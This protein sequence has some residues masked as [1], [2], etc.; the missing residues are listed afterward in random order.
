[1]QTLLGEGVEEFTQDIDGFATDACRP[2]GPKEQVLSICRRAKAI[3]EQLQNLLP[4]F[5]NRAF[6]GHPQFW[7][8]GLGKI[9]RK[10]VGHVLDH[11]IKGKGEEQLFGFE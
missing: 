9:P 5:E 10:E 8:W 11:T 4:L 6:V 3:A 2:L 7:P 1:H